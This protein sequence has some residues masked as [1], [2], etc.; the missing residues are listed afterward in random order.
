MSVPYALYSESSGNPGPQG[1][2][3]LP[4]NPAINREFINLIFGEYLQYNTFTQQNPSL[5]NITFSYPNAFGYIS[6]PGHCCYK[7]YNCFK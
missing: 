7:R 1:P 2:P 5:D 4:G 3:G 6:T